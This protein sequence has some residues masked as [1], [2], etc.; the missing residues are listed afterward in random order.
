MER[1]SRGT[2]FP[3]PLFSK[4]EAYIFYC[5]GPASVYG[6]PDDRLLFKTEKSRKS[7]A[8]RQSVRP[9]LPACR[10]TALFPVR[11]G[12]APQFVFG[13]LRRRIGISGHNHGMSAAAIINIGNLTAWTA[14]AAC[15]K[16][17]RFL[18]LPS[19]PTDFMSCCTGRRHSEK[20]KKTVQ[21]AQP[22]IPYHPLQVISKLSGQAVFRA[23]RTVRR[24]CQWYSCPSISNR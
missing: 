2:C 14:G 8:V 18:L 15:R 22:S 21:N 20:R 12:P 23:W 3:F 16:T 4:D 1:R 10:Q 5:S 6:R 13:L 11:S 17:H 9:V 24:C 19:L 7:L